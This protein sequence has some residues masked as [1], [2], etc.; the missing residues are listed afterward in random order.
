ME[1]EGA[2][3]VAALPVES[4][5]AGVVAGLGYYLTKRA[6]VLVGAVVGEVTVVLVEIEEVVVVVVFS[7][8]QAV[9]RRVAGW[10]LAL[11]LVLVLPVQQA[12]LGLLF[13][14]FATIL[15]IPKILSTIALAESI[16]R[17]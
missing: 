7:E 4:F 8:E 15:S 13:E 14:L 6:D 9:L 2:K 17:Y 5:S 1:E 3:I 16:Y 11:A 12:C 10:A